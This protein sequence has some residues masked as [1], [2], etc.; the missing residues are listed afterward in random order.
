[1]NDTRVTGKVTYTVSLDTYTNVAPEWAK[2][3]LENDGGAWEG[4]CAGMAWDAGDKADGTCW[5]VGTGGYTGYT[6]FFH[7]TYGLEAV[8]NVHGIIYPGSPP[9]P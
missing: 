3:R 7:H 4:A 2:G 6:Y 5:L 9:K 8:N 1:M